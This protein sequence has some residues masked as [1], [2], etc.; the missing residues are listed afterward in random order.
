VPK[1][2][3]ILVVD[4]EEMERLE[5]ADHLRGAGYN[6][7]EAE[8]YTDALALCNSKKGI[9]FLVA[10]IALPDGNG[11]NLATALRQSVPNLAVLFVSGH[12]G[13]EACQYYGLNV[14]DL[15]FLRKPFPPKELVA[16]VQRVLASG[17]PFPNLYV[18]KTW[19]SSGS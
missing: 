11:C 16:R 19:S 6:V 15:H 17:D 7:L 9:S 1:P 18:P 8:N 10:D 2:I 5:M 12:V 4:D 14:T 13:S 3:T